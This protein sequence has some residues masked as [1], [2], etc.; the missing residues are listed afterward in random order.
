MIIHILFET[1]KE[2]PGPVSLKDD[3][4]KPGTNLVA[5]GY[6]LY[7]SATMVVLTTGCGVNGFMLDPVSQLVT[8]FHPVHR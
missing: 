7:G 3:V 5:A 2:T 6:A 1:F 8:L 4:L